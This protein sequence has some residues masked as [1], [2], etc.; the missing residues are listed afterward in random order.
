L[1][2]YIL[3]GQISVAELVGCTLVELKNRGL[4]HHSSDHFFLY[5]NSLSEECISKIWLSV[6]YAILS[7]E[8]FKWDRIA[9][10]DHLTCVSYEMV[11]NGS[12]HSIQHTGDCL[13][14]VSSKMFCGCRKLLSCFIATHGNKQPRKPCQSHHL[15]ENPLTARCL[16]P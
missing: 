8:C 5:K 10:L 9:T 15:E 1:V 6:G 7:N 3:H 16:F 2:H 4:K 11:S 12:W 14:V 13:D